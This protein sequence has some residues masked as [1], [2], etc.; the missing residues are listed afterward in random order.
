M[1]K[2]TLFNTDIHRF[3]TDEHRSCLKISMVI[4]LKSVKICVKE[5]LW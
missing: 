2:D 1:K 3:D 4:C 5:I